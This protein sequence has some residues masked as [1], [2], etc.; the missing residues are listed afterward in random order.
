MSRALPRAADGGEADDLWWARW[1]VAHTGQPQRDAETPTE[2]FLSRS[3][4]PNGRH[5]RITIAIVVIHCH[6]GTD[7]GI[8][9]AGTLARMV[10]PGFLPTRPELQ[11]TP[12]PCSVSG[13]LTYHNAEQGWLFR[14]HL[15]P[16]SSLVPPSEVVALRESN[17]GLFQALYLRRPSTSLVT[18]ANDTGPFASLE[19]LEA[20][21]PFRPQWHR[22]DTHGKERKRERESERV[23]RLRISHCTS[24]RVLLSPP[25]PHLTSPAAR[26]AGGPPGVPDRHSAVIRYLALWA[27]R[28]IKQTSATRCGQ[29]TKAL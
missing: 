29:E 22:N 16:G 19:A 27:C 10:S 26:A 8:S 25:S 2:V 14:S 7:G 17:V 13:H 5:E 23:M 4:V 6:S 15:T 20:V 11:T 18:G 24:T 21:K 3:P 1:A 9:S 12:R 28:G